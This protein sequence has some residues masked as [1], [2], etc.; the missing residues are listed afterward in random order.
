MH[1]CDDIPERDQASFLTIVIIGRTLPA[2]YLILSFFT[3]R[4]ISIH[5]LAWL[6]TRCML[7]Y[8]DHTAIHVRDGG[9]TGDTSFGAGP[10]LASKWESGVCHSLSCFCACCTPC[11]A[12]P[13]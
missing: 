3:S 2:I 6:T 5:I 13:A 12:P 9:V 10:T 7:A 8:I 11:G 1:G 4:R